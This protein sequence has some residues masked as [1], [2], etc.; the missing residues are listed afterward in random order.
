VDRN[1][2]LARVAGRRRGLIT[3][4]QLAELGISPSSIKR[5]VAARA[6]HRL[7]RG[8]Y[9]VGH[10]VPPPL[11][12]ELAALLACGATAAISHRS[13]GALWGILTSPHP[14]TIHVTLPDRRCRP[15][16][17]L[18][19][20]FAPL[21]DGDVTRLH[22]LRVTTAGRTLA[23]LRALLEPAAHERATNEA[24]VLRLVPIARGKSG[25]I[26]QEAERRL[27]ALLRRARLRPDATN[28]RLCGYEV[29]A[30]YTSQRMVVEVDGYASHGTRRAFELDRRR[31]GDLTA[32][33]YRVMRVT[34][35]QL[36]EEPEAVAAR[37][38]AALAR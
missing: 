21:D 20:H 35:R 15:R 38:G 14:T 18:Q 8:V 11:A 13:A 31:D 34:W 32:A 25:L 28:T 3:S 27:Q 7:H 6:L 37:L 26:R 29:D 16:P 9:L 12:R 5:R 36:E 24:E 23:D 33:G 1:K 2:R 19:P 17:G 4:A 30:L 10:P 22:G